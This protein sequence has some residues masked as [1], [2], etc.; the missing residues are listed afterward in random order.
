MNGKPCSLVLQLGE[1][2]ILQLGLTRPTVKV[3]AAIGSNPAWC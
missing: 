1:G 3:S 2:Q